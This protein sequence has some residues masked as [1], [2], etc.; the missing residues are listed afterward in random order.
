L[1][2]K[3][4]KI[5]L[6]G[7]I[8]MSIFDLYAC[9]LPRPKSRTS[10]NIPCMMR[11]VTIHVSTLKRQLKK[12]DVDLNASEVL[13]LEQKSQIEKLRRSLIAMTETNLQ[14]KSRQT[15]VVPITMKVLSNAHSLA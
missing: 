3:S 9:L 5:I 15:Q 6:K 12:H 14:T 2:L 7:T 11:A 8:A 4:K 10:K 1:A 13:N